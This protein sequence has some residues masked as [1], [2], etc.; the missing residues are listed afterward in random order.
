MN[1]DDFVTEIEACYGAYP[2]TMREY[3]GRWLRKSCTL[4]PGR[5]FGHVLQTYS[6]RWGRPPG[7]VEFRDSIKQLQQADAVEGI[8]TDLIGDLDRQ[9]LERGIQ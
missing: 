9:L 5:V 7:I 8:E 2:T 1:V 3:V 4:P 6:T